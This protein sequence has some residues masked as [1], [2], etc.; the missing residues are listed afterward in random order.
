MT[1]RAHVVIRRAHD[2]H[3]A[4]E[5][6]TGEVYAELHR[7]FPALVLLQQA[8]GGHTLVLQN[9]SGQAAHEGPTLCALMNKLSE[10]GFDLATSTC[11]ATGE[12]EY[13]MRSDP[14][15]QRVILSATGPGSPT[16]RTFRGTSF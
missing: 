8:S 5:S 11:S 6:A 4:I 10:I 1:S 9:P 3:L 12:H 7:E 13:I 15:A 2:G 14:F 16:G